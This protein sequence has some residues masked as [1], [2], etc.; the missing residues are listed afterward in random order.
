M[1]LR[2]TI[3]QNRLDI[4]MYIN[5]AKSVNINYE[6]AINMYAMSPNLLKKN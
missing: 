5:Y 3:G 4:L 2:S 1:I 6:E